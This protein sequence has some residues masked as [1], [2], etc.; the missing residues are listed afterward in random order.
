MVLGQVIDALVQK[1][2]HVPYYGSK[3]TTLLAPALGGNARTAVL[4]A[5]SPVSPSI[6]RQASKRLYRCEE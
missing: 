1:Q 2:S 3:L 6:V 5:A 4:V